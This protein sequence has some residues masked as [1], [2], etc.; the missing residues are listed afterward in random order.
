V[1]N[2]THAAIKRPALYRR[3]ASGT[4]KRLGCEIAGLQGDLAQNNKLITFKRRQDE[5][6]RN[7]SN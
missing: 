4:G 3:K 7:K 2:Y 5:Y 6:L 1:L